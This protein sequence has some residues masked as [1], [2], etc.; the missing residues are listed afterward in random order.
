MSSRPPRPP[1]VTGPPVQGA[2]LP[3]DES[4]MTRHDIGLV[5]VSP[6]IARQRTSAFV[7]D[8]NGQP[9]QLGSGR[10]A[11]AVLGE[12]RWLEAEPTYR[13]NVAIKRR[14]QGAQPDAGLR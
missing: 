2:P 7:M 4:E 12:E 6:Y 13:R 11:K 5:R 1:V 3:W 10:F 8:E 14:Q 9:I